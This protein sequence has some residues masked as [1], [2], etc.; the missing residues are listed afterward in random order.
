MNKQIK[1]DLL[2][3]AAEKLDCPPE[4]IMYYAWPE[5]F[6][7][8][9]GPFGGIGGQAITTMTMEALSDGRMAALY[10]NGR[11]LNLVDEFI[12]HDPVYKEP[13]ND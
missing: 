2:A 11:F 12:F 13:S 4:Y 6:A 7:S 5:T 1:T 10:C 8:T 9:A 3:D